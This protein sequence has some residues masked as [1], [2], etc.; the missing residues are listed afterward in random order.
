M[1][2]IGAKG[3]AKE[4]LEVL[5]QL[6]RLENIAFYDD[7][8]HDIGDFLYSEFPILKSELQAKNFFEKVG[9]E[10]TIGIGNPQLRYKLYKKFT[11]LGGV[12][13]STVSPLAIIGSFGNQIGAGCNIMTST[14][15]TNDIT[16]GEG[17]LINLCCTVGHDTLIDDFVELCPDV[18]ISGNCHIGKFSFI[19][20]NSTVLPNVRIG[21]NVIVG[22][23]SVVTKDVPD[24]SLVIGTPA[25]IKKDL[26]PFEV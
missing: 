9:S 13:A 26:P 24:N 2:I 12:Y 6:N 1:L 3:F 23:G 4:V 22:A 18:N 20:T 10:F 8:N 17:V 25:I 19:G 11:D 7:V 16:I 14:V 5:K 15:I 21:K